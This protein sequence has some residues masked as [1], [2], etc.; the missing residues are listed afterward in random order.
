MGFFRLSRELKEQRK[1]TLDTVFVLEYMPIAP[2]NYTKVYL[3]GLAFS[4]AEDNELKEIAAFLN[5]GEKEVL[6]IFSY[7]QQMGLVTVAEDPPSVEY[8]PVTPISQRNPN[9]DPAKYESFNKQLHRM[10]TDREILP[11]EYREYYAV[12][13]LMGV[14]IE[15]MLTII[16]YCIQKK[17]PKARQFI[18]STAKN[19]AA[20]GARTYDSVQE[21]LM[22]M[23]L[24]DPALKAVLKA[25]KLPS[26]PNDQD[27]QYFIKW[28]KL[29]FSQSTVIGVAKH[30]TKGGI[31]VLD[32]LLNQYHE[33][34]LL[35]L[36]EIEE[37]KQNR[38]ARYALAKSV[39]NMFGIYLDSYDQVAE[40]YISPWLA[41]GFSAEALK[42][43]AKYC[44]RLSKR[45]LEKMGREVKK[46][47]KEGR[48]AIESLRLRENL[49]DEE[50]IDD[51]LQNLGLSRDATPSE[52]GDYKKWVYEWK[53]PFDLID[54]ACELSKDKTNQWAYMK[55]VLKNWREK[56]I[57][58]V[59]EAKNSGPKP[60]KA[61]HGAVVKD[62]NQNVIKRS[63]TAQELNTMFDRLGDD[64]L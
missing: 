34:G 60:E 55:K 27:L 25:L 29:G 32:K 37:Y 4:N 46:F 36:N 5:M 15:A 24:E 42:E 2:E 53:M 22:K 10:I 13:E 64:E 17:G 61:E 33:K 14:E 30:V 23:E 16:G 7:W 19:L 58:T 48:I 50:R 56:N 8:R 54:Y 59:E 3:M 63:L 45:S 18:L 47:H 51:I 44:F 12:M 35:S 49:S 11:A 1:I 28:K 41:M 20:H 57:A 9:Y 6:N 38:D 52:R 26:E 21:Q 62:G 39:A 43:I 40:L 31:A